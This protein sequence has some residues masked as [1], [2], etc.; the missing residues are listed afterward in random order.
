[1]NF[2]PRPIVMVCKEC[3]TEIDHRT[4][5]AVVCMKKKVRPTDPTF[6]Y[7][8]LRCFEKVDAL[9]AQGA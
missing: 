5:G 3:K 4:C 2:L 8:C 7:M 6:E 9:L 1:M